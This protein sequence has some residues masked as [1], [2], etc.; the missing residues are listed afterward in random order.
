MDMTI[1]PYEIWRQILRHLSRPDLKT[2]RLSGNHYL[3]SLASS[4]LFTT[5][6][7]AARKAAL[8]TFM[9]LTTHPEFSKYVKE[10]VY[11]SSFISLDVLEQNRNNK[12]GPELATL[13]EEQKDILSGKLQK[14]LDQ[15]FKSLS[16]V[17]K[18]RYADMSRVAYLPGECDVST[19][20]RHDY[21]DE[22]LMHRIESGCLWS[23]DL[24]SRVS[25]CNGPKKE[26]A[27]EDIKT[28]VKLGGFVTLMQA[29]ANSTTKLSHLS[30]GQSIHAA[31]AGGM[32]CWIFSP[33]NVEITHPFLYPAFVS[34]LKLDLTISHDGVLRHK[35]YF[36]EEFRSV[37]LANLL[38]SAQNLQE[39]K[40]AGDC[41]T[42]S[43]KFANIFSSH[44]WSKLRAVS[45]L[46]FEGSQEELVEFAKRHSPSLRYMWVDEF[47]LTSGSWRFL[48]DLPLVAPNLEFFF[49]IVYV[50]RRCYIYKLESM[51]PLAQEDFNES[52]LRSNHRQKEW[53]NE[54]EDDEGDEDLDDL[55][56]DRL[57][58]SSDDSTSSTASNPRRKPD[59]DIL[60]LMHSTREKVES[61]RAAIPGYPV[62]VCR[63]VLLQTD[64]N[65]EAGKAVLLRQLT[66]NEIER[67]VRKSKNS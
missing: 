56:S 2:L 11:D 55:E 60:M 61:I 47:H 15:A 42:Y 5:A 67:L 29:L 43:L 37:N 1:V 50:G 12:C 46:F 39:V 66:P 49:G 7:V 31:D 36:K 65:V 59:L 40:L 62:R 13:F 48:G 30:L 51:F 64:G 52:G 26:L 53:S 63:D 23:E 58:Y 6:Y 25:P 54:D 32:S 22:P 17:S 57:S 44:T 16:N 35:P 18:V 27:F 4:L 38:F 10:V 19:W 28:H 45:L 20:E 9:A 41:S 21:Q 33:V 8:N 14:C 3:A 34:L 24:W